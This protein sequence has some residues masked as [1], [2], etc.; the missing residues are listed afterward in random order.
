MRK[1]VESSSIG[2]GRISFEKAQEEPGA[3]PILEQLEVKQPDFIF[4]DQLQPGRGEPVTL[5]GFVERRSKEG[6]IIFLNLGGMKPDKR[7]QIVAEMPTPEQRSF[8]SSLGIQPG[9]LIEAI[10]NLIPREEVNIRSE[11]VVTNPLAAYELEVKVDP[12]KVNQIKVLFQP[13]T[14]KTSLRWETVRENSELLRPDLYGE[15]LRLPE[16]RRVMKMRWGVRDAFLHHFDNEGFTQIDVPI[17]SSAT[18]ESGAEVFKVKGRTGEKLTLIQ[19]P[20][21]I[22]QTLAGIV[23]G[24][25][26]AGSAFRDDPSFTPHHL[27]EFTSLDMEMVTQHVDKKIAMHSVM[28]KLENAMHG[29]VAEI[30]K[31][32]GCLKDNQG[33]LPTFADDSSIS[34]ISYDQA[35]AYAQRITGAETFNR[36][37]EQVVGDYVKTKTGSDFYFITGFPKEEKPFYTDFEGE[38][39]YSFDL[40]YRGLE[41]ASGGLRIADPSL[42]KQRL[43]EGGYDVSKFESYLDNFSRGTQQTGG[44]GL[45]LERIIS[46]TLGINSRLTTLYP[47]TAQTILG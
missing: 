3:L 36:K 45:G 15:I 29:I 42:L 22:K 43:K 5:R 1:E 40:I 2:A 7:L 23:G 46:K 16:F 13:E 17:L 4:V 25:F 10:G 27:A 39:S 33:E 21:Q 41:I 35:L 47:K 6:K 24:V 38:T 26:W 11:E 30:S 19:S 20:Q 37:A 32:Q 14:P 12:N 8:F 34:V 9:T 18:A 31:H 28:K 44:F